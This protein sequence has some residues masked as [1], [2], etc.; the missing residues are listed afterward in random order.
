MSGV[1]PNFVSRCYRVMVRRDDHTEQAVILG[2]PLIHQPAV[3]RSR[4]C[5]RVI[6]LLDGGVQQEVIGEQDANIHAQIVQVLPHLRGGCH[7]HAPLT[8]AVGKHR[9]GGRHR[10]ESGNVQI[11]LRHGTDVFQRFAPG[12]F[13]VRGKRGRRLVDVNVSINN[14]QVFFVR[15]MFLQRTV[16]LRHALNP[17]DTAVPARSQSGQCYR[18][19]TAP[20][21]AT[22]R[23]SC[24][25]CAASSPRWAG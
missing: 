20:A 12:H 9:P 19:R 1:T 4:Q 24:R 14:K 15:R 21:V 8:A 18:P 25:R 11:A 10:R 22:C 2:Q 13:A 17:R 6:R 7:R 5:Y 23:W 3:I 16:G